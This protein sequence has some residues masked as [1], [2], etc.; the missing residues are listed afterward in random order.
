M[1]TFFRSERLTA[2]ISLTL[3][4]GF[5]SIVPRVRAQAPAAP[6]VKIWTER[7]HDIEEYL[8]VADVGKMDQS[9]VGVTSPRRA[10]TAPGG[11]VDSF[12]WKPIPP[13]RYRGHWESYKSE[14]AAYELDKILALDMFPPAVERR[15]ER[16]SGRLWSGSRLRKASSSLVVCRARRQRNSTAGTGRSSEPR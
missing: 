12:T 10:H 6:G 9:G 1:T 13:G 4:V 5:A 3:V 11:L 8:R 2:A 14:I 16:I 15:L 7:R